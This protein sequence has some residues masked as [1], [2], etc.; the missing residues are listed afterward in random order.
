MDDACGVIAVW[1]VQHDS[2]CRVRDRYLPRSPH[3]LA[4]FSLD[5]CLSTRKDA[6]EIPLWITAP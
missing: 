3:F 4:L 6:R 5:I 2:Q 1:G